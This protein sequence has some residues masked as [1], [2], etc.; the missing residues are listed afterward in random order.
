M[1]KTETNPVLR[2]MKNIIR[3]ALIVT[4]ENGDCSAVQEK[5]SSLER[6]LVMPFLCGDDLSMDALTCEHARGNTELIAPFLETNRRSY[7]QS[8]LDR[9]MPSLISSGLIAG[10]TP[11][12][13]RHELGA[14][15]P[16][17]V[18]CLPDGPSAE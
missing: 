3:V 7:R 16:D 5:K 1:S 14:I 10:I 13:I 2:F 18:S 4:E 9:L 15:I 11:T 17:F 8:L 6:Q 12:S